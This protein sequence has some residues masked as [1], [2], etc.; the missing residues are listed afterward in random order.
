MLAHS[1][2]R[3]RRNVR[4]CANTVW[5]GFDA[6]IGGRWGGVYLVNSDVHNEMA[7]TT[8]Q[9]P[10][11]AGRSK[12]NAHA[13]HA[14]RCAHVCVCASDQRHK[15]VHERPVF[16]V[17]YGLCENVK[18]KRRDSSPYIM[19]CICVFYLLG[20]LYTNG[21]VGFSVM[22]KVSVRCSSRSI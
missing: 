4:A 5:P 16:R 7:Q 10:V 14:M 17:S 6:L 12:P 21:V 11:D 18:C 8:V 3:L 13:Q 15:W 2:E 1:P 20:A 9:K 22:F 19:V